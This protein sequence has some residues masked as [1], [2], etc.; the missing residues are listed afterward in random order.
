[1]KRFHTVIDS[2]GLLEAIN[3]PNLIKVI[4]VALG[5]SGSGNLSPVSTTLLVN[6]GQRIVSIDGNKIVKQMVKDGAITWGGQGG[7]NATF[8]GLLTYAL[9]NPVAQR[10]SV[11]FGTDKQIAHANVDFSKMRDF[12]KDSLGFNLP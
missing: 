10:V 4:D 2:V 5:M 1:M 7:V 12:M 3:T 6:N 9:E 11:T 8:I